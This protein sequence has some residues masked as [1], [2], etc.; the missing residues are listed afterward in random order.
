[1]KQQLVICF[2]NFNGLFDLSQHLTALERGQFMRQRYLRTRVCYPHCSQKYI[3]TEIS[4]I[5]CSG[6]L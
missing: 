1:M 2:E 3:A 5:A 6:E 4:I